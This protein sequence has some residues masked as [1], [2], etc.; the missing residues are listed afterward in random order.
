MFLMDQGGTLGIA[1]VCPINGG[2]KWDQVGMGTGGSCS[3][4]A[5]FPWTAMRVLQPPVKDMSWG[6]RWGS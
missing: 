1:G 2:V 5:D 4:P 3:F 6:Q